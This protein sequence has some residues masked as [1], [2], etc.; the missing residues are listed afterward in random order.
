[1]NIFQK[2]A[3][4]LSEL[5]SHMEVVD[6]EEGQMAAG[7]TA[8][9]NGTYP[10][11]GHSLDRNGDSYRWHNFLLCSGETYDEL[12]DEFGEEEPIDW[13][14]LYEAGITSSQLEY[15]LSREVPRGVYAELTVQKVGGELNV[16]THELLIDDA[17]SVARFDDEKPSNNTAINAGATSTNGEAITEEA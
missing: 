12:A 17:K 8:K 1:M 6:M 13:D 4:S 16:E 10:R 5:Q 11:D 9:T 15:D 3:I 14:T 7:I 2:D